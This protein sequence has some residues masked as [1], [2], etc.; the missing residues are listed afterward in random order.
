MSLDV[1]CLSFAYSRSP[2]LSGVSLT[3][4]KGILMGL[5]GPNGS[6]KSTLIKCAAGLLAPDRGRVALNGVPLGEISRRIASRSI[7]YMPQDSGGAEGFTVVE[8]VLMGRRPYSKWRPSSRDRAI[9]MESLDLLGAADLASRLFQS[10]SGGE[11]QRVVLCR[12]LAQ[13]SPYLLMDEPVAHLDIASQLDVMT[14]LREVMSHKETG[15]LLAI[16]DLNLAARYCSHLLLLCSGKCVAS[17]P[18][19][20]VLTVENIGTTFG[21]V[22]Q[23]GKIDDTTFILPV[24]RIAD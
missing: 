14:L 22:A 17:G 24:E 8:I 21:I 11:Q 20:S 10:L 19:E 2:V 1:Q 4:E 12:F 15:V 13:R 18:S 7:A 23:M 9:A 5:I 6:G 3:L 16:H